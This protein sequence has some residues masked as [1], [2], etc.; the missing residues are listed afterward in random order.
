M[1]IN[2]S[3]SKFLDSQNSTAL[4]GQL[5]YLRSY[6][7]VPGLLRRLHSP[8]IDHFVLKR[9][10]PMTMP[11]S[12]SDHPWAYIIRAEHTVSEAHPDEAG[13]VTMGSQNQPQGL[14]PPSV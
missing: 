5:G 6:A 3:G 9:Y 14:H 10:N 11:S 1:T 2:A 12:T 13:G 7:R 4:F 8:K